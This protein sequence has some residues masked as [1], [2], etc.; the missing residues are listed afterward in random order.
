VA[1]LHAKSEAQSLLKETHS[2]WYLY[3]LFS[4]IV[5]QQN[6]LFMWSIC[7]S[8]HWCTAEGKN[9]N[10]FMNSCQLLIAKK[11]VYIL[12]LSNATQI[13]KPHRWCSRI[14]KKV[15]QGTSWKMVS[16]L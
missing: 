13:I 10:D 9:P 16:L 1:I 3:P 11:C 7:N 14:N 2:S 5:H 8:I 15:V 6:K 4:G 12:L